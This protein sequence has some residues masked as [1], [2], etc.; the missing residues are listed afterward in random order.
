MGVQSITLAVRAGRD[1]EVATSNPAQGWPTSPLAV[2]RRSR[3]V[4]TR[5][6]NLEIWV[7]QAQVA[8]RLMCLKASPARPSSAAFQL[9]ALTDSTAAAR[10]APKPGWRLTARTAGSKRDS[11]PRAR[12]G[13]GGPSEIELPG[14]PSDPGSS[15]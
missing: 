11:R 15:V 3:D 5:L 7:E 14:S 13:D 2:N 9:D 6:F 8:R 10:N 1:L 12:L 4:R